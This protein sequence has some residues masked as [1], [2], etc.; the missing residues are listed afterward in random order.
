[1][2]SEPLLL[3]FDTS[4]AHCAAALLSGGIICSERCVPMGRGQAEALMPLLEEVLAEQALSW[5]DLDAIAVGIGPGNFTGIRISVSAARGL[6]LARGI[7]AIGISMF[8]VMAS[9]AGAGPFV[10]SLPAPRDMAYV[11]P[12]S[13]GRA[14]DRAA[15]IDPLEP[16]S[17][18]VLATSATVLG[19]RAAEI[20]AHLGANAVEAGLHDIPARIARIAGHRLFQEGE[21]PDRPAPLYVRA[22]D[23]APPADPPPVILP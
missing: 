1:M 10:V 4:A 8:E 16:P 19:H 7:P 14:C 3:A 15:L 18:L 22:A 5:R 17:D 6:A 13:G 23:A 9:G 2:R 20:G 21:T 12:L 11:Q